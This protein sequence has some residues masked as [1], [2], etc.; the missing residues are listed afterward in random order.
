MSRAVLSKSEIISRV[1]LQPMAIRADVKACY[2]SWLQGI[3]TDP[4]WMLIPHDDH[5]VH[6]G[7]G[8]FEAI[9]FINKKPYLLDQHLQRLQ[10][11][12]ES[13]HFDLSKIDD[14]IAEIVKVTLEASG[15]D[16]GLI[17]L[18]VSRGSGSYSPNPYDPRKPEL[19]VAV[20]H[21]LPPSE[22][23]Y[24]QGGKLGLST[25]SPK[26]SFWAQIKSCN[27]L[28]NVLMKKEAVDRKLDFVIGATEAGQLTESST[29]NFIIV[30]QKGLLVRPTRDRILKGCTMMRAFELAQKNHVA[31]TFE[32]DLTVDDLK[33][34]REIMMAGT[35]LDILPITEFESK[36]VGDGQ[37]GPVAKKLLEL[38]LKDQT[39]N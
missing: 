5:M 11:S 12:A 6:R 17:R 35:T 33:Q 4:R 37:V 34:A 14:D 38:M 16:N 27:Y 26:E 15:L 25:V 7:D 10:F 28:P 8:I 21:L 18:F 1:E 39:S 22:K 29:E 9:K 19:T 24:S 32:R 20:M 2:M 31:Q 13:L 36:R 30:D 23:L 3:V